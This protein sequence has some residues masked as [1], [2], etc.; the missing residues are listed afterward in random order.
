MQGV[1]TVTCRGEGFSPNSLNQVCV[2]FEGLWGFSG[3]DV[4]FRSSAG[5]RRGGN[6]GVGTSGIVGY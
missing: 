5:S 3:V 6:I 4:A 1:L 2:L